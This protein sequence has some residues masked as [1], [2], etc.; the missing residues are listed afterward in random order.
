ILWRLTATDR[1][2]QRLRTP[3][4]F[5]L[6]LTCHAG[7]QMLS[8]RKHLLPGN[9]TVEISRKQRLGLNAG[10]SATSILRA[11]N[12]RP[13][14]SLTDAKA[15]TSSPSSGPTSLAYALRRFLSASRPRVM[16]DFTVPN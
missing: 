1:R 16:R 7:L 12:T 10:H 8:D 13:S 9:H 5:I 14:S 4:G 3:Q 15:G 6:M 2:Q 11:R